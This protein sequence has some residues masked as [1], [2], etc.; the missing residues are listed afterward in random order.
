M[1][2]IIIITKIDNRNLYNRTGQKQRTIFERSKSY[3]RYRTEQFDRL[4]N[5]S[6]CRHAS[7]GHLKMVQ[8][9]TQNDFVE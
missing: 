9:L 2:Q 5:V 3:F 1:G 4:P 7:R 8:F 6:E